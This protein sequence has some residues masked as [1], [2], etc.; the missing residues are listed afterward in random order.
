MESIMR[1]ITPGL[2]FQTENAWQWLFLAV[3]VAPLPAG[4][5]AARRRGL[6]RLTGMPP[7][8]GVAVWLSIWALAV[9]FFGFVWDVTWHADLGRDQ[10]L[11]TV[12]HVLILLGLTGI[13][14]AF[15]AAV[16]LAT[17]AGSAPGLRV[18]R[19]RVPV[20]AVPLGLLAAGALAAFPL[21][22]YWHALYGIDVTM[23]SPT[24]LLMI[25]AAS[26]TPIALWLM[27][28]EAGVHGQPG[29]ARLLWLRMPAVVLVGLS[30]FQ[31]EFDLG[32]PQWQ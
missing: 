13:G 8:A 27:L 1:G 30:T 20:S 3:A 24:H 7:W 21:D 26:L 14:G 32:V 2:W 4:L 6:E 22:A 17:R 9:A 31:L 19:L 29:R 10:E 25:G 28:R 11:F 5:A 15:V 16:A 12:P 23:W 18:G